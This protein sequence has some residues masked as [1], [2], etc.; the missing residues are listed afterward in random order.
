MI[1]TTISKPY[2]EMLSDKYTSHQQTI[3]TVTVMW[4]LIAYLAIPISS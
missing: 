1:L 3:I 4:L 2:P